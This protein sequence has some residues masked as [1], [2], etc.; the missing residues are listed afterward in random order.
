MDVE[1]SGAFLGLRCISAMSFYALSFIW[2][3]FLAHKKRDLRW[4]FKGTEPRML[5][6]A[7]RGIQS[8]G[9]IKS[10]IWFFLCH[11]DG[12]KKKNTAHVTNPA[13]SYMMHSGP[14]LSRWRNAEIPTY[15]SRGFQ[16]ES[17]RA[18]NEATWEVCWSSLSLLRSVKMTKGTQTAIKSEMI[19]AK[20][21]CVQN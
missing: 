1:T 15:D 13:Y 9:L 16:W 4:F 6:N 20:T 11:P 10:R 2:N 8:S 19:T 14:T 5:L 18:W 21:W 17:Q 7:Q 12:H 3:L